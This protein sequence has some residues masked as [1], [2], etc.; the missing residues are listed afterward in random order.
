MF[1]NIGRLLKE[2]MLVL[3]SKENDITKNWDL[4]ETYNDP[5]L[6]EK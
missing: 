3:G 2:K 1:K 4:Y 6:S 5:Y